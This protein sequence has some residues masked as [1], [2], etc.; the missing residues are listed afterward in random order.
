MIKEVET[1]Q[2]QNLVIVSDILDSYGWLG[3]EEVGQTVTNALFL[4][5][6]HSDLKTQIKYLPLLQKAVLEEK[7]NASD[8]AMLED[9]MAVKKGI[10]QKYGSQLPPHPIIGKP[11]VWPIDNPNV[12]DDL[13]LKIGL[14]PMNEYV[15]WWG[16]KWDVKQHLEYTSELEEKELMDFYLEKEE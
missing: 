9:K 6:Q 15:S 7:A 16:I 11:M 14:P 5:I 2:T 1:R 4:T 13:R 12:V 3:R 8:V 10:K